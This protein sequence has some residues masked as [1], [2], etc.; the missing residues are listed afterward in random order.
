MLNSAFLQAITRSNALI[1]LKSPYRS[2][3]QELSD[4]RVFDDGG[5]E[6]FNFK[7]EKL[8]HFSVIS[9]VRN[10]GFNP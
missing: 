4:L 2:D 1:V 5:L 9:N 3:S 8:S 10:G 7:T 6:L